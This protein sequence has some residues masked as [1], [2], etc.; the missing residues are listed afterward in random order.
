MQPHRGTTI[1]LL[2]ILGCCGC[3][4]LTGLPAWVMANEDLRLMETGRM[5]AEGRGLTQ[6]GKVCGIIGTALTAVAMVT[7]LV[8]ASAPTPG[9]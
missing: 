7:A 3:C 8:I 5:D 1:L 9:G 2:G 4:A 6:A